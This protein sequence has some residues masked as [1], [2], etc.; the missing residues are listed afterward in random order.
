MVLEANDRTLR[1]VLHARQ[2]ELRNLAS[3]QLTRQLA[4]QLLAD[5]QRMA[6]ARAKR[7]QKSLAV[8]FLDLDHFKSINDSL[9]HAIG[10]VFLQEVAAW[11]KN[12]LRQE[13]TVS[14]LGGDEF[15]MIMPD[16]E[17]PDQAGAQRILEALDA[18]SCSR[19]TSCM[20]PLR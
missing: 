20:S 1:A 18:L 9:G 3:Q 8:V 15:I 12:S 6:L 5:R 4:A 13:D 19:S 16:V 11:L 7:N 2:D 10:D 14:R 17:G